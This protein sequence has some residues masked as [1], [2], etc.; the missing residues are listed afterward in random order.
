MRLRGMLPTTLLG[1]SAPLDRVS[2]ILHSLGV[3]KI[4]KLSDHLII[5]RTYRSA[6]MELARKF[7]S[8]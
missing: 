8:S 5:N 6:T 4:F 2:L 1:A 3:T 7:G